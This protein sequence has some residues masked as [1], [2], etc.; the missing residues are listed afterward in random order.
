M[1]IIQSAKKALRQTKTRTI[2][3]KAKKTA[4]RSSLREFKKKKDPAIIPLLY[5]MLDK[6]A[7]TGL[8]HKN[9]AARLKS[10]L[11]NQI[12]PT[13]NPKSKAKENTA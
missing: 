8:I 10:N 7:K 2:V 5:S 11:I 12:V 9:K 13:K 3:N 1:P 4:F 6:M